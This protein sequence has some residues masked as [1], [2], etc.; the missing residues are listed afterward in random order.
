M[1]DDQP[2]S[3]LNLNEFYEDDVLMMLRE[4]NRSHKKA[5]KEHVAATKKKLPKMTLEKN[6]KNF[7][8]LGEKMVDTAKEG[9]SVA[10]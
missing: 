8:K 7:G 10:A 2:V 9:L 3:V 6:L 1:I 5:L 4:H